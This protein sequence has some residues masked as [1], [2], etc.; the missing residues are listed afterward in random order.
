MSSEGRTALPQGFA[1]PPALRMLGLSYCR[2]ATKG[3]RAVKRLQLPGYTVMVL[4]WT[5]P[6]CASRAVPDTEGILAVPESRLPAESQRGPGSWSQPVIVT[7]PLPEE[8]SP[9]LLK[10]AV[11]R[12]TLPS[13]PHPVLSLIPAPSSVPRGFQTCIVQPLC[14]GGAS[15]P[16]A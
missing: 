2:L 15:G 4:V 3:L 14:K 1:P 12:F 16:Q 13:F 8:A 10:V 7:S 9:S 11:V 5:P 6:L